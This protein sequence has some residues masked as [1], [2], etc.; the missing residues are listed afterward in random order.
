MNF[1]TDTTPAYIALLVFL[2]TLIQVKLF[3]V[4]TG[5]NNVLLSRPQRYITP[6]AYVKLKVKR[7]KAKILDFLY[8]Y[9]GE[10]N[11][12]YSSFQ[13]ALI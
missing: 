5:W 10:K 1:E 11:I 12:L 2:H 4:T 7:P 8:F 6:P 9:I 13:N 3:A